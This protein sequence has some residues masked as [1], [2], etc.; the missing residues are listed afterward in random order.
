MVGSI[1]IL[2]SAVVFSVTTP[3]NAGFLGQAGDALAEGGA[4]AAE[5]LVKRY[6]AADPTGYLANDALEAVYLL[7]V[8][9]IEH[10]TVAA[11][12]YA[13]DAMDRA[14]DADARDRL[15]AL[16]GDDDLP[17]AVRGRAAILTAGLTYHEKAERILTE[18][19]TEADDPDVR[20]AAVIALAGLY[21]EE[22]R[23]EDA[24]ELEAEYVGTY[25]DGPDVFGAD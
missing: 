11:Y 4:D 19:W 25:T 1:V 7:R 5:A 24:A 22:G 10:D 20:V 16:A 17:W 9:G 18:V 3:A 12:L 8:K 13:L 6:V 2:L 21:R 23:E 14:D 15:T